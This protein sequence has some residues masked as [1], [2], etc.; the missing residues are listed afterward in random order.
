[1]PATGSPWRSC[2]ARRTRPRSPPRGCASLIQC[3]PIATRRA[4]RVASRLRIGA[5]TAPEHATDAPALLRRAEEALAVAKRGD[6]GS[7]VLYD[8]VPEPRHASAAAAR[9]ALRRRDRGPQ[10]APHRARARQPV[11]DARSRA[12]AFSEALLR[13]SAA[14][15]AHRRRRRRRARPSSAPASSR[16]STRACWSSSPTIS[17]RIRTSAIV[18]QRLAG[19]ARERPTGSAPSRPISAPAPAS[20][21]GSSSR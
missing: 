1:M 20:P 4:A 17:P 9:G 8:A 15:G 7:F 16:W 11:V 13:I 2:P 21:R 19:D 6:R 14:D 10:R 12:V 18:D 5:A 3:E